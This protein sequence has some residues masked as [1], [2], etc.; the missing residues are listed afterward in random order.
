MTHGTFLPLGWQAPW[1]RLPHGRRDL[2]QG[3]LQPPGRLLLHLR[4]Q[5][6]VLLHGLGSPGCHLQR[7]AHHVCKVGGE[8]IQAARN[9]A[10]GNI[11]IVLWSEH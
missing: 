6:R 8:D 3:H 2:L 4:R 11:L 7:E 10:Q 9:G 5:P 1:Q